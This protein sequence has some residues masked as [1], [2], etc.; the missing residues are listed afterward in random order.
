MQSEVVTDPR[1]A[2]ESA[3]NREPHPKIDHGSRSDRME[4]G[5]EFLVE[6]EVPEAS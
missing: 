1:W 3:R 6:W 2:D 4:A 5:Q